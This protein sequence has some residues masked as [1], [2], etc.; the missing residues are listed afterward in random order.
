MTKRSTTLHKQLKKDVLNDPAGR[1]E[2]EA[3]KLQLE[4]ADVLKHARQAAHLTQETVA[5]RMET[6]K[7]VI[8][9][10]EAAGGRSKHSPSLT[11]LVKYADAIG[12]T[13]DV[14]LK[15]KRKIRATA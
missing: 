10:L 12:Y 6:T 1:A 2:Y 7:S 13:L 11:T 8:A 3:F 15:R 14:A 5:D 9:R 4:L